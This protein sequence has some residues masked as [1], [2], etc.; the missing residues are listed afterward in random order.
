[1]SVSLM[2]KTEE[3]KAAGYVLLL[4]NR[5]FWSFKGHGEEGILALLSDSAKAEEIVVCC[6]GCEREERYDGPPPDDAYVAVGDVLYAVT[7]ER[8]RRAYAQRKRKRSG[9][10]IKEIN[11]G[12]FAGSCKKDG[13][14][15]VNKGEGDKQAVLSPHDQ[16][17]RRWPPPPC[18][19]RARYCA[20]V[21]TEAGEEG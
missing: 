11:D 20:G 3:G 9:D 5:L 12:K 4:E 18:W 10:K 16:S 15:C 17:E 1:M 14:V 21:W 13:S 2:L 7:C 19:P 8:A 6:D